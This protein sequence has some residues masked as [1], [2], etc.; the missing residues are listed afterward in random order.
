MLTIKI[1]NAFFIVLLVSAAA[2]AQSSGDLRNKYGIP[3]EAYEVRPNVL[4]TVVFGADGQACEMVIEARH[5]SK[6]GVNGNSLIPSSVAEEI[7]KEVVPTEKRGKRGRSITFSGGCSSMTGEEY[8][9][10]SIY[11]SGLCLQGGGKAVE[12][13]TIKWRHRQCQSEE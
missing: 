11:I 7:L 9:N 6:D 4:M 1:A 3:S 12:A 5:T 13:I 10:V 8:E 2:F